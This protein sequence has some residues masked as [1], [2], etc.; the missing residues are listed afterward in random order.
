MLII[1]GRIFLRVVQN[2][3]EPAGQ[4]TKDE[5]KYTAVLHA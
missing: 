3:G 1:Y 4:D 2:F 5:Y